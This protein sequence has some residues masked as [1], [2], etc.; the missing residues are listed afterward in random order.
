[1]G[2]TSIA[3]QSKDIVAKFFGDR[4]KGKSLSLFGLNID[5]RVV[6]TAPTNLPLVQARE[7]RM[8]NV[9][10]LE[11][12][13]V[14][15]MDYESSC[16]EENFFKYGSYIINVSKRYWLDKKKPDIH[17]LVIYTADVK[18]AETVWHK[19]AC[20]IRVEA[21]YLVNVDSEAWFQDVQNR[22]AADAVTDEALMHLI[23]YPLTFSGNENKQTAIRKSVDLARTMK[24]KE[25]ES[26]ALA[27]ILAFTD[28]VISEETRKEIKEVLRMTQ[29]GKMLF[30]E[31]RLEGRR[32]GHQEGDLARAR[33]TAIN[34]FARGDSA[35]AIAEILELPIDMVEA[36][37]E[38]ALCTV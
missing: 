19:T 8:D 33:K 25:Q 27:G 18:N 6:R 21:A 32:E 13:S 30:D 10:E 11:D 22:I 26:F 34:M 20:D 5:K 29:V 7:L 1:M 15:I 37:R 12:D 3:Y 35:S 28:K 9:F 23:L 38:E 16:K 14:A 17:M 36:W 31:G 24:D 2:D 4:M